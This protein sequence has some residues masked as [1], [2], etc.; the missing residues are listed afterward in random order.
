MSPE[1]HSF[2]R[3]PWARWVLPLRS[4][5]RLPP[6]AL[7]SANPGDAQESVE[8]LTQV[9]RLNGTTWRVGIDPGNQGREAKWYEAPRKDALPATVPGV[10]Q[11][12]FPE[13]HGV[14]WYWHEFSAPS[15]PHAEG[16]YWL[17]FHA[18]DYLAEVWVNGVKLGGHEGAQEPFS[19]DATTAMKPGA[20]N[21]LAVRVLNPTHALIDGIRLEEVAE[22]AAITPSRR[23]TPTTRVG[24]STR[25]IC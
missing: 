11:S 13:Y 2:T 18:V 7:T 3:P 24:S 12:A 25:W 5:R 19:L 8:V 17:R 20:A 16:R 21:I 10:I 6:H 1:E 4:K 15:N 9:L 14:A 23:I 22:A